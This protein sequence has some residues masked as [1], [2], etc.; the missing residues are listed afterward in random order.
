MNFPGKDH[1]SGLRCLRLGV[2]FDCPKSCQRCCPAP[3]A[4]RKNERSKMAIADTVWGRLARFNASDRN[5]RGSGQFRRIRRH[6]AVTMVR[7]LRIVTYWLLTALATGL[8]R[9]EA[10]ALWL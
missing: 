8:D 9:I 6:H 4:P 5:R 1:L 7:W 2:A 10:A 3:I